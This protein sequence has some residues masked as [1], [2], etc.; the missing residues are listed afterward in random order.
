MIGRSPGDLSRSV[1]K[2]GREVENSAHRLTN[3]QEAP[4]SGRTDAGSNR[5][6]APAK[7][8]GLNSQVLADKHLK[9]PQ[10]KLWRCHAH[11]A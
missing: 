6:A 2:P 1:H 10:A 5:A 9:Y 4:Q 3:S 7:A 11:Q 8:D